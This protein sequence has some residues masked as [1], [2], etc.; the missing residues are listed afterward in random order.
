MQIIHIRYCFINLPSGLTTAPR[1]FTKLFKVVISHL[2]LKSI[3]IISYLDDVLI[4]GNSYKVVQD[5]LEITLNA[6]TNLDFRINY[7]KSVHEPC[8]IIRH[9]E[10]IWNSLHMTLSLPKE[11]T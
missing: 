10:F 11:K 8:Q 2:R 5:N 9:L 3:K 4:V 7:K 6:L 1:N